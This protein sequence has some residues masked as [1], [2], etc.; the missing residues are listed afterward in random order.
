[1]NS[2]PK[3]HFCM[4][5]VAVQAPDSLYTDFVEMRRVFPSFYE[6]NVPSV[7][8]KQVLPSG[9]GATWSFLCLSGNRANRKVESVITETATGRCCV[10]CRKDTLRS[11]EF[12][13][14]WMDW[15]RVASAGCGDL[16]RVIRSETL[17]ILLPCNKIPPCRERIYNFSEPR[18]TKVLRQNRSK[19]P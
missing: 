11:N 9:F 13:S 12:C 8:K 1:M 15:D 5:V 10:L 19:I 7:C 4:A 18:S 17:R 14:P 3:A 16:A 2:V 6:K